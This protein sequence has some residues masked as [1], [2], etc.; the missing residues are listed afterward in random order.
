MKQKISDWC[1]EVANMEQLIE[2]KAE[3]IITT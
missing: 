1:K 3:D 2:T